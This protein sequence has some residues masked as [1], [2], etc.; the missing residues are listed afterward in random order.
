MKLNI[1]NSLQINTSHLVC[2]IDHT[3]V[4]EIQ[5]K[6]NFENGMLSKQDLL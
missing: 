2:S 5:A 1:L 6:I 4:T 3:D